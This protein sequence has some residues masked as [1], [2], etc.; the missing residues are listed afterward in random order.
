[1]D[2]DGVVVAVN[3]AYLR[4]VHRDR[5][6]LVGRPLA[7][8]VPVDPGASGAAELDASLRKVRR[9]GRPDAL[10][11]RSYAVATGGSGDRR[12]WRLPVHLPLLDE[13]GQVAWVLHR[14]DE[15][16]GRV[17]PEPQ[18]ATASA[19]EPGPA[20]AL[21]DARAHLRQ[22]EDELHAL[23]RELEAAREATRRWA[24]QQAGLVEL[25][26]SAGRARDE[27]A[28][29]RAVARQGARLLGASG[30]GLCLR[31]PDGRHV[32]LL[33][34]DSDTD[35]DTDAVREVAR[36]VPLDVPSPL[37]HTAVTGEAHFD[38]GLAAV[39]R[40]PAAEALRVAAD[41]H[42]SAT[43]PL[44]AH[45]RLLGSLSM[46]CA[47]PRAWTRQDRDLLDAVAA[48]ITPALER[49]DPRAAAAVSAG[50]DHDPWREPV[51]GG[52]Q[53]E[54]GPGAEAEVVTVVDVRDPAGRGEDG[55]V[56][57]VLVLDA[58]PA[59]VREARVFVHESC[60]RLA[61]CD[62]ACDTLALL[63]SEVV[64]NAI[65]HGRSQTRLEVTS[66]PTGVRLEVRDDD[67]RLPVLAATDPQALGGRGLAVVDRLASAWGVREEDVGKTVWV[68]LSA[69]G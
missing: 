40:V 13:T 64:T 57:R 51:P 6:D 68:E 28:V 7:D 59:A 2:L 42:A 53:P 26:R 8:V 16:L 43:V 11:L 60:C 58:D 9:T 10:P 24:D 50:A 62:D 65:S 3:R 44:R 19:G 30:S 36:T 22:A 66:T 35:T 54:L 33:V 14:A 25:A 49:L 39:A 15:V 34:T 21:R 56:S 67:S 12:R 47:R 41:A 27:G 31:E 52:T 20:S 29:L 17:D 4:E 38:D 63:V 5:A 32:R 55:L 48:L 1:M 61:H 23:G 46:A 69:T 37:V 45:G 18:P